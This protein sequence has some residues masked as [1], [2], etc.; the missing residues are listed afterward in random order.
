M[1]AVRFVVDV[2]RALVD[3]FTALFDFVREEPLPAFVL[4][5]L[6]GGL[7]SL[8]GMGLEALK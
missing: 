2:W 7:L 8:L 6:T 1:T 5:S 3:G 4:F